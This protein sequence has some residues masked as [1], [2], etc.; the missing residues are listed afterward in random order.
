MSFKISSWRQALILFFK[1]YVAFL[2]TMILVSSLMRSVAPNDHT[3][4]PLVSTAPLEP[5]E[6]ERD[7]AGGGAKD[8]VQFVSQTDTA[9]F[10]LHDTDK[11]VQSMSTS[12]LVARKSACKEEYRLRGYYAAKEFNG[13]Q[14]ATLQNACVQADKFFKDFSKKPV[15]FFDGTKAA[16]ILWKLA[17]IGDTI[18]DGMPHTREDVIFVHDSLIKGSEEA[19]VRTLIHEKV[20]IYQRKFTK[21]QSSLAN[22]DGSNSQVFL[23]NHMVKGLG[24]TRSKKRSELMCDVRSNP[25]VDEWVYKNP[26]DS[27]DMYLCYRSSNPTNISDVIGQHSDEHPYEYIAYEIAKLY[28]P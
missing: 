13:D 25:D 9:H 18:E 11:Y 19:L 28:T 16:A 21:E 8:N 12:D 1:I 17:L 23:T 6:G 15:A 14:K 5:F 26:K 27:K 22:E 4:K 20:H 10:L 3:T 24:F 2:L 7:V